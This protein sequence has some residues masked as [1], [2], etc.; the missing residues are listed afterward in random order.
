[1]GKYRKVYSIEEIEE[2]VAELEALKEQHYL[3]KEKLKKTELLVEKYKQE[4]DRL[5]RKSER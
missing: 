3:L 4:V 1:M 2:M 5:N